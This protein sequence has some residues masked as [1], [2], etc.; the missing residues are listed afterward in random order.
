MS[1][2]NDL[3]GLMGKEDVRHLK[4]YLN[5]TRSN[6]N[7]RKDVE[8][9][10]YI[11]KSGR[12]YEEGKIL[13]KLYGKGDKNALYRLKNRLLEDITKSLSLQYFN[14]LESNQVL[15]FLAMSRLYLHKGHFTV[16]YHFLQKAEKKANSI[17]AYELLDIVYSDFIKHSHETLSI[18]PELYIEKRV[19]NRKKLK[20]LRE[21][22]DILA[23]LIYRLKLS[24]GYSNENTQI[25]ELLQK[26]I[27]DFS[28]NE[29]T[30]KSA[31]LRFKVYDSVSRILLQQHN[32]VALEDYLKLTFEEFSEEGLF[33]KTTHD[34]KLQMLTYLV[35]SLFKNQKYQESLHFAEE[36]KGAMEEYGKGFYNKYLLYYYN[37]LISNYSVLDKEKAIANLQEAIND[38][39]INK[40][41]MNRIYLFLNMAG[42][43]FDIGEF[44]KA[45][46]AIVKLKFE[47]VY[48][49][50]DKAFQLKIGI[51]E[52]VIRY[53]MEDF[54]FIEYQGARVKRNFEKLLKKPAYKRQKQMLDILLKMI[55][56]QNFKTD[57]KLNA[58][59]DNLTSEIPEGE[60]ADLDILNYNT[61]LR[62]KIHG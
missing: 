18:N 42:Q 50:L 30:K 40:I 61:W 19:E 37:A 20:Q 5:R 2:L 35:N 43:Y 56:S 48:N 10:D 16:A 7:N 49:T 44:R 27:D 26:T 6:E 45:N 1:V 59:I 8:L 47:D 53:E 15:H 25:V 33:N 32:F 52:L 9:F 51:L 22:D 39:I 38:P 28:R 60:A 34:T 31:K 41:P 11:R 12:E 14:Y 4:L 57:Q 46:R 29:E 36:L 24:Q 3:I 13:T 54:D 23:V 58:I 17:Q 55:Y 62:E 21:I